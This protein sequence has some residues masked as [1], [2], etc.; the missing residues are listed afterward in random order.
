M[1]KASLRKALK[2]RE[3]SANEKKRLD[4]LVEKNSTR[5]DVTIKAPCAQIELSIKK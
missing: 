1:S 4:S 5:Q 3:R 2:E